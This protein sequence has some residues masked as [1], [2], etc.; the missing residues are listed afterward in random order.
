MCRCLFFLVHERIEWVL[1]DECVFVNKQRLDF[2][3][4]IIFIILRN[5]FIRREK[6][7]ENN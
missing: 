1:V 6:I 3:G 4:G 5:N 7:I 2:S